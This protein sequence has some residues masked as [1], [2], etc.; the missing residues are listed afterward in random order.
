MSRGQRLEFSR[1]DQQQDEINRMLE[2]ATQCESIDDAIRITREAG[3][4]QLKHDASLKRIC[5][6]GIAEVAD[7]GV[8]IL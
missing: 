1:L 8:T 3:L 5:K 4:L 6:K 7:I 2:K